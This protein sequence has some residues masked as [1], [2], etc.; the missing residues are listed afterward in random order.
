MPAVLLCD[1][2]NLNAMNTA[3]P[4]SI[5]SDF[6]KTQLFMAGYI[7]YNMFH[8]L[9]LKFLG[10]QIMV[11]GYEECIKAGMQSLDERHFQI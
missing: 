7:V 11:I 1:V 9:P 4:V 5:E 8:L 10:E 3:G 6:E 2:M